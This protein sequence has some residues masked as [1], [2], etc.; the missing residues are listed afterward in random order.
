MN[1]LL[2]DDDLLIL[3]LLHRA[4]E[5]WGHNVNVYLNPGVCPAY[6]AIGTTQICLP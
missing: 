3:S 5:T 6:L 1:V 4:F 2:M